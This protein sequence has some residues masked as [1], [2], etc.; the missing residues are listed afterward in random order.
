MA[1]ECDVLVVGAGPGG[2]AAALRQPPAAWPGT[3]EFMSDD[4]NE[5]IECFVV[6]LKQQNLNFLQL[7]GIKHKYFH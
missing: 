4:E 1:T 6:Y 2:G 7:M 3:P 5:E